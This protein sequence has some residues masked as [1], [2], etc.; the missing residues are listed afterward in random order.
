M[1]KRMSWQNCEALRRQRREFEHERTAD[2]FGRGRAKGATYRF[3]RQ[4]EPAPMP[5]PEN[6]RER[7]Q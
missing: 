4:R 1:T 3:D 7:T 2:Y 5:E 6:Y